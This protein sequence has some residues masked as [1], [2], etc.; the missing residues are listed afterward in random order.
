[1]SASQRKKRRR[2]RTVLLD[3]WADGPP[4]QMIDLETFEIRP[5]TYTETALFYERELLR[6][7]FKRYS[8]FVRR[9]ADDNSVYPLD[10][11]R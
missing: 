4:Y 10:G 2:E 3:L 7:A 6:A 8:R 9:V 11:F 1:M 5:S